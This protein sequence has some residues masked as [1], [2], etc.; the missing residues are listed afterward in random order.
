MTALAW[1]ARRGTGSLGMRAG[2]CSRSSGRPLTNGE[3]LAIVAD[4]AGWGRLVPQ[5]VRLDAPIT[6]VGPYVAGLV[7]A[8]AA[9]MTAVRVGDP[10]HPGTRDARG[11]DP[12][13]AGLRVGSD[14]T[15]LAAPRRA[16]PGR[17]R[18]GRRRDRA[19]LD[20]V[21]PQCIPG[22]AT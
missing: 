22:T 4:L 3:L 17:S 7:R 20:P 11:R 16:L 21:L 9:S 13:P 18:A 15:G 2:P 5:T 10:G 1:Y 8:G 14:L 6:T 19:A 12:S